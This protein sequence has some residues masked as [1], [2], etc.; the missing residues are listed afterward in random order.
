[1]RDSVEQREHLLFLQQFWLS[2]QNDTSFSLLHRIFSWWPA[3]CFH[4][5]I[6]TWLTVWVHGG[7]FIT[8]HGC[9]ELTDV[10]SRSSQV[11]EN[12][13]MSELYKYYAWKRVS[14]I[15]H[16]KP[17][18]DSFPSVY[19]LICQRSSF[20]DGGLVN[21]S[22]QPWTIPGR[23]SAFQVLDNWWKTANCN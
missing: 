7:L 13:L 14:L 8:L 18:N 6:T 11:K 2:A 1:M 12:S 17:T 16:T 15:K 20:T 5:T 3:C 22:K 9:S 19:L 10:I 21:L 23:Q 4:A